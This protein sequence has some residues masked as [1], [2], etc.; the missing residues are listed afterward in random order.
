[1]KENK[2]YC[3]WTNGMMIKDTGFDF[4][5]MSNQSMMDV[6]CILIEIRLK[7]KYNLDKNIISLY[8]NGK[9]N[10]NNSVRWGFGVLGFWGLGLRA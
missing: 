6:C 8:S 3:Y 4:G 7:I 2:K 1:M 10:T 5:L 9:W